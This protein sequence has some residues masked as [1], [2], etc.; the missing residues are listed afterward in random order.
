MKIPLDWL[1]N[2]VPLNK[3]TMEIASSFTLL[4]L[5]LDKP[6]ANNVLDL[7]HRMDRADWLSI[8]GCARDIA[9]FEH[10]P[11]TFPKLYTEKGKTP[12]PDQKVKIEVKCPDKVTRFNTRVIRGVKVQSSPA[13]LKE[14]LE[15]YG[16]PSINN[17][18][19][20]TNFV[21]VELGQPMHAQDLAKMQELGKT[22]IVIRNAKKGE[23][24]KTLLGETIEL[25][26]T[27]F[28]LTQND[29]A[30]VIGGIVGGE[31][32]G[33]DETTKDIILD[34]GN[35]NQVNIRKS[36]RKLKIQNET[37]LRYDKFLHPY[38]C[39]LA[40]QRAVSLILEL[41][42]GEYYENEDYYPNPQPFKQM[43]LRLTRLTQIAGFDI[44]EQEVMQTL[45]LLGY[46]LLDKATDK[47]I[48]E[49]PYFRTDI[50]VEDDIVADILRIHN[51][52]KIELEVMPFAPPK[53]I[54]PEIYKYEDRLRKI[55]TAI[56]LHEHIT[57]PIVAKSTDPMQVILENALNADKSALRTNI[58]KTLKP[59]LENY[60]KNNVNEVCI[61]ELGKTYLK[62]G[63][64][65]KVEDFAE[66]RMLEV[67]YMNTE[68]SPEEIASQIKRHLSTLLANLGI[69]YILNPTTE[70][71]V[72][73]IYDLYNTELGTLR[74]DSFT[75]D[76]E[77]LIRLPT[78]NIRIKQ[79]T[80]QTLTNDLTIK[81]KE[82]TKVA[83][84]IKEILLVD[85]VKN[86]STVDQYTTKAK[87]KTATLRVNYLLEAKVAVQGL[88]EKYRS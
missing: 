30:T 54:T 25:D 4:G 68:K 86:V 17:I 20:I 46:K 44:S 58:Y 22:E 47:L 56:G 21:M 39:E 83:E 31:A 11:F 60:V 65:D 36:S 55:C 14:K 79:D 75:L 50:E 33:V 82:N 74:Y 63:K 69:V 62:V 52:E 41:A 23:I 87:E 16:M 28:V 34:A 18:V 1:K 9:A 80:T 15:A 29:T 26:D 27:M 66:P 13:W 61:F 88:L 42:G 32:T 53:E 57:D 7:E 85:G 12:T 81:V 6:L 76:V 3:T 37:V 2:Y 78:T 67:I 35:Y 64:G 40:I 77:K 49:I 70:K 5:M 84:I 43:T 73:C 19:D 72:A 59:V 8:T 24:V 71:N 10:L 38:Q 51:Y 48:L 45:D